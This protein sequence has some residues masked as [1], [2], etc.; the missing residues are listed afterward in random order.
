[1]HSVACT[2]DTVAVLSVRDLVGECKHCKCLM[3]MDV[4][5][6][7]PGQPSYFSVGPLRQEWI[8]AR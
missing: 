3:R 4:T 7:A 6:L 8:L 1:M 5:H 2:H